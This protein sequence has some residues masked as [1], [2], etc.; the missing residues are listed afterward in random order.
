MKYTHLSSR[1]YCFSTSLNKSA[2]PS[3]FY[4]GVKDRNWVDVVEFEALNRNNTWSITCLPKGR[5]PIGSKW[6]FKIKDKASGE[7]E[8][9]KAR[10]VAKGF[11]QRECIDYDETFIPIVTMT[12]MRD[13]FV[14]LLVYVDDIVIRGSNVNQIESFKQYLKILR[15]LKGSP[16]YGIQLAAN[17]IFHEKSKHFEIDLHLIREKV[18]AG[19]VKTIKV[20]TTQ[21]IADIFTQGLN[22]KQHQVCFVISE[23]VFYAAYL[24]FK[25]YRGLSVCGYI[26]W[27]IALIRVN[28]NLSITLSKVHPSQSFSFDLF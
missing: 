21:Q 6:I 8:R 27:S 24:E 23:R 13:T 12:T 9:Y 22:D 1:N 28:P 2:E 16:G 10:Q 14:A 15:Y 20:H 17:P 4:V 25:G 18:S 19:V 7:I 5:K 11:S 26:S 3:T